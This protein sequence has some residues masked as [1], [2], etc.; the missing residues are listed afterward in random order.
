MSD[1]PGRETEVRWRLTVFVGA[2]ALL[3]CF[4]LIL[5]SADLGKMASALVVAP[6][7]GL[8][9]VV[10]LIRA[11]LRK[12]WPQARFV[13][14]V[15]I[16]FALISGSL[17]HFSDETRDEVRWA[18]HSSKFKAEVMAET[19]VADDGMR[20]VIWDGWG[21]F[22]QDTDVYLVYDPTDGLKN[23]RADRLM[24]L[25]CP[26][27]KVHRLEKEWYSVTFFTNTGW[28]Y[29]REP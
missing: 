10:A 9:L 2:G 26:V 25:P 16:A 8:I 19:P 24:G 28:G 22:A 29:C 6:L 21:M 15:L 1:Q 17:L 7:A 13:A 4:F 18:F 11:A 23:Y 5:Y 27:W 14:V 3:A 12:H 20:H